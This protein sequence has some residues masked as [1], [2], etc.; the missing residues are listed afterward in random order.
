MF[1][2]PSGEP[3]RVAVPAQRGVFATVAAGGRYI[4]RPYELNG[5]FVQSVTWGD[6]DLTDRAFDLVSDMTGL[7]VT[8]TDRALRVTGT[9]KDARGAIAPRA[10]VLAF[11]TDPARW[12][13]Y[14]SSP[15][16]IRSVPTTRAGT[17]TFQ[18]LP[19]GEYDLIAVAG[20][21]PD[22][23][24]DPRMLEALA[25]QATRLTIDGTETTPKTV[26]LTVKAGR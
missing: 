21:E 14:G 8:F 13:G 22:A 6:E 12:T 17:Y 11:P 4:A 23:W 15:R 3:G 10:T 9:V 1:E 5:W 25:N 18:N 24:T 20:A 2:T 16:D 7:V 26:D 19:A